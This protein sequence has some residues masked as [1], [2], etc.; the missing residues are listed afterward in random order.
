MQPMHAAWQVYKTIKFVLHKPDQNSSFWYLELSSD[1][2]IL[3]RPC[4]H[5]EKNIP[6]NPSTVLGK[7]LQEQASHSWDTNLPGILIRLSEQQTSPVFIWRHAK[8]NV[9]KKPL[10]FAKMAPR[11]R[12]CCIHPFCLWHEVSQRTCQKTGLW[13]NFFKEL[14]RL[15]DGG[16]KPQPKG[17]LVTRMRQVHTLNSEKRVGILLKKYS[18]VLS[19]TG[20]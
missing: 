3:H 9:W 10:S 15:M 6:F 12:P 11:S 4:H 16:S 18:I 13:P 17:G 2:T 7:R 1:W 19:S 14:S 5:T 20:S 8:K